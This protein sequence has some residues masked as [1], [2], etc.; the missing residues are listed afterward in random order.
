MKKT[1]FLIFLISCSF[2]FVNYASGSQVA[3]NDPAHPGR[4]A[5]S[6]DNLSNTPSKIEGE[7]TGEATKLAAK[8]QEKP[9]FPFAVEED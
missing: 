8:E 7:K 5:I 6:P 1:L 4:T 2:V 9:I 3:S